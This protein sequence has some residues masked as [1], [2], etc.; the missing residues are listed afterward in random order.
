MAV[1]AVGSAF[2]LAGVLLGAHQVLVVMQTWNE[3][4]LR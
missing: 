3:G 1:L 4:G 2:L